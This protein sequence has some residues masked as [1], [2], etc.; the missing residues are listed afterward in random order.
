[1]CQN[2]FYIA[3][4][5]GT[6]NS[7]IARA[8]F[9]N[10]RLVPCVLD[11]PRKN[12]TGSTSRDKLLPSVVYYSK[13]RSGEMSADVGNYAK[14]RYGIKNNYVCKSVKSLM[15]RT[16]SVP[17]AGEIEDKT[18]ADVSAQI[19]RYLVNQTKKIL[20]QTYL[21]DVVITVPASFDSDQCQATIDAA[22]S[23]GL[24]VDNSHDILLYEP[25]AVIYDFMRMQEDGEIPSNLLDLET[26]K[27]V[28]VFDLGGG[29]LDV[30][31][32]RVGRS[33]NGLYN[34]TDL[35]ISRYTAIGGDN[36]DELL[37]ADMLKKFEEDE[38]NVKISG[39]R[40]EEVMCKLRRLAES[41]KLELSMEYTNSR[42]YGTPIDDDCEFEVMDVNLYDSYALE[43]TYTKAEIEEILAPLMG[44]NYKID[45]VKKIQHMDEK[46][47][48]NI[49]YPILD[50]LEKAG[51]DVKIDAVLLNGGMTKFYLIT[52][53]LKEFFGFEPLEISD[54][55]LAVARGAVYYHY[56]LHKYRVPRTDY[57]TDKTADNAI[58]DSAPATP[59][60][61][62][63]GT[64][65]NDTINIGLRNEYISQLIPAG[66]TLPYR[67]EEIRDKF[68]LATTTDTLG[69]EL[70]LGRGKSKNLPNRRIAT[71][72]V[73]FPH[74]YPAGTPISLQIY[75][76]GLRMMTLEAWITDRPKTKMISELGLASLKSGAKTSGG[77]ELIAGME[78]N[79]KSEINDLKMLVERNRSKADGDLNDTIKRKLQDIGRASNPKDFFDPCLALAN[80]LRQSDL[81]LSCVYIMARYFNGKWTASQTRQILSLAKRHFDPFA[82]NVKQSNYVLRSALELIA[83]ADPDFVKFYTDYLTRVPTTPSNTRQSML[84]FTISY[85]PDAQKIADFFASYF[86]LSDMNKWIAGR[87][88]KSFGRGTEKMNQK[89][90]A[91]LTKKLAKLLDAPDRDSIPPYLVIL[92]V[93]LFSNDVPNSLHDDTYTAKAVWQSVKRYLADEPDETLVSAAEKIWNGEEL[94]EEEE[95]AAAAAL[96]EL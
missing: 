93:E 62:N 84:Q 80:N 50:V 53:R 56:C 59:S 82:G 16:E 33:E 45:D 46:D 4:D 83:A 79:A 22:R 95:T 31:L 2:Q 34:I 72:T 14:S 60:L 13:N 19:L 47:V 66:I 10:G 55:D 81:M 42:D 15:G 5:L 67:S 29:T 48:N 61:F 92:I 9:S 37:A 41:M 87:L 3:I 6:T 36:F 76:S 91:K 49:I 69:I 39:N 94:S 70:F 52:E 43:L 32:H 12:E 54:P 27:N 23:A 63:T 24:N 65:L 57:W 89:A 11:I 26:E 51:G 96:Y 64:I 74:T 88:V 21:N 90:F 75:I 28:M 58:S 20:H 85:Q 38:D 77:L 68:Q 73:K 35:A 8:N 86:D 78:L 17:L 7:V 1:M 25:K 44:Y 18:P 30:T 71:R 40:R